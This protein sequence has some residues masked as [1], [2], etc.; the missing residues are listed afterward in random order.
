M[1]VL[2]PAVHRAIVCV[3]VEGFGDRRRTNPD[4]VVTR[5]GLYGALSRAFAR[6]GMYWEDCYYEDRGD[7]AASAAGRRAGGAGS[8]SLRSS[9]LPHAGTAAATRLAPSGG[10]RIAGT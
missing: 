1:S 5:D 2:S 3:D 4:Q 10:R 7:G 9:M 8:R 6:S